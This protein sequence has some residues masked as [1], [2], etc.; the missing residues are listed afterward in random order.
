[1]KDDSDEVIEQDNFDIE[2]NGIFF[3]KIIILLF[4][5]FLKLFEI[6]LFYL[7]LLRLMGTAKDDVRK[8]IIQESLNTLESP[9]KKLVPKKNTNYNSNMFETE[10]VNYFLF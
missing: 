10:K 1:M 2:R 4:L 7:E 9:D 8:A 5:S 6:Y 3:F